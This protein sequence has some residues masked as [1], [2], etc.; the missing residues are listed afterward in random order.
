MSKG[1]IPVDVFDAKYGRIRTTVLADGGP[2]LIA[3]F[4]ESA[5]ER[6]LRGTACG[7]R[8]LIF[9]AWDA[10]HLQIRHVFALPDI[11]EEGTDFWIIP[12][13]AEPFSPDW[14]TSGSEFTRDGMRLILGRRDDDPAVLRLVQWFTEEQ[15]ASP[16]PTC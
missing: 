3:R 14:G 11:M 4:I 13:D 7:G 6:Q 12:D 8:L 9:P 1:V 10:T 16:V 15:Y 2:R 5:P